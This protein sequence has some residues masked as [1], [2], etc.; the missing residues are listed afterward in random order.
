MTR[1]AL[2]GKSQVLNTWASRYLAERHNYDE[3]K[4]GDGVTRF[5]RM[6]YPYETFKRIHY[7]DRMLFYDTLYGID[8]GIWVGFLKMR[9]TDSQAKPENNTVTCDVRYLNELE[10]LQ[11]LGYITVRLSGTNIPHFKDRSPKVMPSL[12]R[13]SLQLSEW[14]ERDP[15]RKA[16]VD[17]NIHIDNLN[18]NAKLNKSMEQLMAKLDNVNA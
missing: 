8:P 15:L 14:Y 16:K 1:V 12:N 4:L 11:E 9:L 13:N 6:M 7:A 2:I 3:K 17:Y 18:R 10:V 5:I